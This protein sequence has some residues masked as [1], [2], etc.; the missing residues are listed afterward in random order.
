MYDFFGTHNLKTSCRMVATPKSRWTLT[1]WGSTT[2][3]K[4]RRRSRK[5]EGNSPVLNHTEPSSQPG[6]LKIANL[7][8]H[9]QTLLH[10]KKGSKEPIILSS[11]YLNCLAG[12]CWRCW[13]FQDP[14][15]IW[16]W[17]K[18]AHWVTWQVVRL[19]AQLRESVESI[20]KPSTALDHGCINQP[21]GFI[22]KENYKY[23]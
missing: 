21:S 11:S 1:Q 14:F 9:L 15:E 8:Q 18:S 5:T 3:R 12:C 2:Q 17:P 16:Q 23:Q 6:D 10:S 4:N 7:F 19:L 20:G 22:Q 13:S